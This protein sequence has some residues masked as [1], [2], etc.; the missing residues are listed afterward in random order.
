MKM[1]KILVQIEIPAGTR[2]APGVQGIEDSFR[3]KIHAYSKYLAALLT[4][5]Q[6]PNVSAILEERQE[7]E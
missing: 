7:W 1:L 4:D 3:E 5:G 2:P 6:V